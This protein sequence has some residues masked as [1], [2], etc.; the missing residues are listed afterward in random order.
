[1]ASALNPRALAAQQ[2]SEAF[3]NYRIVLTLD[4]QD[5]TFRLGDLNALE[6]RALRREAQMTVPEMTRGVEEQETDCVAALVWLSR[7]QAGERGLT[8]EQ[9]ASRVTAGQTVTVRHEDDPEPEGEDGGY[10]DPPA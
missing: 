4:G 7:R 3:V 1:M 9:V 5:F 2:R 6:V 10:P 8:F